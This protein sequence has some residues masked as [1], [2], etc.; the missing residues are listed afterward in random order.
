MVKGIADGAVELY[1][2]NIKKLETTIVMVLNSSGEAHIEGT[3]PHL[4]LQRTDNANVP[5]I[6]FKGSGGNHMAQTLIL[7]VHQVANETCISNIRR[8]IY[9]RTVLITYGG[10]KVSGELNVTSGLT[11]TSSGIG[12]SN[13]GS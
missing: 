11:V 8:S 7:M 5:T 12:T 13:N 2:N 4:T 1:H 3:T 10:A 9:R 6:R